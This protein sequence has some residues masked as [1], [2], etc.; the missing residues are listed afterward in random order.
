[1][2]AK[3]LPRRSVTLTEVIVKDFKKNKIKYLIVLPVI[4]YLI[5]FAYKPMYGVIIAFKNY[6][7]TKGIWGSPWV[8]F[9]NFNRFFS[10]VFFF[11]LLR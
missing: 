8:G 3:V 7:A 10:D 11:R 9:E 5:I 2:K 6:K 4:V 1:M